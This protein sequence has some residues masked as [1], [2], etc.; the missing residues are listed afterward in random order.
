LRCLLEAEKE[1][2]GLAAE[3]LAEIERHL[4]AAA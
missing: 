3:G 1:I 2:A 4:N